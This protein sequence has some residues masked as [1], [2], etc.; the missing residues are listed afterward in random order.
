LGWVGWSG[1]GLTLMTAVGLILGVAF[2]GFVGW[3]RGYVM[4]APRELPHGSVAW[5]PNLGGTTSEVDSPSSERDPST[6]RASKTGLGGAALSNEYQVD[7]QLGEGARTRA[8]EGAFLEDDPA[9]DQL[10]AWWQRKRVSRE[11]AG[12]EQEGQD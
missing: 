4:R 2:P 7:L 1:L 8:E 12:S 10:L 3:G 5:A 11:H 9:A 6:S